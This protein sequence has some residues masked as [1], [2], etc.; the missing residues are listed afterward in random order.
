V[1]RVTPWQHTAVSRLL[2]RCQ[3]HLSWTYQTGHSI[4][5]PD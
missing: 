2:S 5:V 3:V 4:P 1:V